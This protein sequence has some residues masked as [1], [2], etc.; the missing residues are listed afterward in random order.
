M[1]AV[2]RKAPNFDAQ[3]R[4]MKIPR[5]ATLGLLA[6]LATGPH[7]AS[8]EGQPARAAAAWR[9]EKTLVPRALVVPGLCGQWFPVEEALDMAEFRQ[10][11]GFVFNQVHDILGDVPPE[12]IVAMLDAAYEAGSC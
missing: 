1:Q 4:A 5:L 3:S 8:A 10:G 6:V 2:E 12:N 9:W 11:G 7:A